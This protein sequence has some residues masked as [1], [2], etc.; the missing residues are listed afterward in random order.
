M[1]AVSVL[2]W[3]RWFN[4]KVVK[5][6]KQR[7]AGLGGILMGSAGLCCGFG[8]SVCSATQGGSGICF[9]SSHNMARADKL[10][11]LY[12]QRVPLLND[13]IYTRGNAMLESGISPSV[14]P[15]SPFNSNADQRCHAI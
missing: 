2:H 5:T 12:T 6:G 10:V 7:A 8:G 11:G 14:S 15:L 4:L 9:Q 3:R 13:Y 1:L